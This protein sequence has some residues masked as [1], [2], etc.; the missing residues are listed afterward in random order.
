MTREQGIKR[1]FD[2]PSHVVILGAGASIAST[3]HNP[4]PS[5]KKVPSMKNLIEVVGLT[6]IIE[7]VDLNKENKNFEKVYSGMYAQD[8]NSQVIG[9]IERRVRDYF[10]SLTLPPTPTIYDYLVL[11]LRP[12]DLIATFNWDPFLYQA[13]SRNRHVGGLPHLAFLHGSVSI[14]YSPEEQRAGPAGWFSKATGY[15]YVPTKLLYPVTQ[16]NYNNDEFIAREWGRLKRWIG[17]AKRI[18]IFGYSA[19]DTDVEAIE[20]MSGAWGDPNQRNLEQVEVIDEK[21]KDVILERWSRFIHTHHYDYCTN[22]FQSVLAYFPRRT[23]ERF[24]HQFLPSTP[25]EAFQEPNPVS[26]RFDTLEEMW[27]WHRPLIEAER[28]YEAHRKRGT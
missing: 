11:A 17:F 24:M 15:E 18:T 22:Y 20:L 2:W 16:K 28:E 25:A 3:N 10:Q 26:E 21:P 13:F 12:K 1:V 5:G 27:E 9:E 4:E 23:G 7:S 8:P 19:P 14:G 6:D